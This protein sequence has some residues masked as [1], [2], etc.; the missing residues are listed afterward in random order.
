MRMYIF[1]HHYDNDVIY[2]MLCYSSIMGIE[3][4]EDFSVGPRTLDDYLLAYVTKGCFIC[5][6]HNLTWRLG[7]GEYMFI[8]LKVPHKYYFD[9]AIPSEI[10]W[11]HMNGS[12][13][14]KMA[15][16]IDLLSP[17][18]FVG[19]DDDSILESIRLGFALNDPKTSDF[20]THSMHI[21]ATLTHLLETAYDRKM[22]REL[23]SEEYNFRINFEKIMIKNDPCEL[24]LDKICEQM[25]MSKYYFLHQFKKYYPMSP[26]KYVMREKIKKAQ[27][28]LNYST[29][30]I[31]AIAA[32]CGFSSP[33][34]FSTVFR[35]EVGMSPEEYRFRQNMTDDG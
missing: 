32:E 1:P 6:Q 11:M 20:F 26:M 3:R 25:H 7:V 29:M 24:S 14:V 35:R 18:P 8:N 21:M 34:Y 17:L 15:E 12:F 27:N 5:E 23:P 2:S 33:A 9:P 28:L 31:A 22:K 13:V 19:R 16:Y 30:K 4:E 10:Y